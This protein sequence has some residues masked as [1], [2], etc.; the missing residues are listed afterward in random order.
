MRVP[1]TR[2]R[3]KAAG[4]AKPRRK[5]RSLLI[6]CL[7]A[8]FV[9][10]PVGIASADPPIN[11]NPNDACSPAD[12]P[13]PEEYGSGIDGMVRPPDYPSQQLQKSPPERLTYYDRYGT[14]GQ[15]WHPVDMGC[16]DA[17]AMVGNSVSNVVFT[18]AKAFDRTTITIYEAAAS[19]SLLGWL[20]KTVDGVIKGM[21]NTFGAKYWSWVVILGA[22]W[23]AW[24]GLIRRRASR[25][26]EGTIW[27]VMAMVALVWL[28]GRP[29]DFTTLGTKVSNGATAAFNA[30]LPQSNADASACVPGGPTAQQAVQND[31]VTRNANGLWTTLVCKPWLMGEFG[32][33]DAKS[34]I[35]QDNAARLL[36][37]QAVDVTEVYSGKKPDVDQKADDYKA[38]TKNIKD[39][40]PGVYPLFQGKNWTS[41]LAVSFGALLAA[42]VA[43][44][45]VLIIAVMLMVLKI[46]FLLLLVAGPIFL[47]IGIHPGIGRVI[48][49]RWFELLLST[50]LKQAALIG[51]LALLLWCYGLVMAESLPWG[52]QILLIS[53]VTLAAFIYRKPFQH[54]FAAV[55]YSAVGSRKSE[56]HLEQA[57][58]ETRKRTTAV[59]TAAVPGTAG[60]RFGRWAAKRETGATTTAPSLVMIDDA[61]DGDREQAGGGAPAGSERR[62][63]ASQLAAKAAGA[64][65]GSAPPLNLSPRAQPSGGRANGGAVRAPRSGASGGSTRPPAA[66][67]PPREDRPSAPSGG[68]SRPPASAIGPS[69]GA[70]GRGAGGGQG[71]GGAS[72]RR[73][74]GG[75]GGRGWFGGGSEKEG[76][77]AGSGGGR[78]WFGGSGG[79]NAARPGS[80]R[81][82]GPAKGGSDGKREP[83]SGAGRRDTDGAEGGARQA[84]P[85]WSG[86]SREEAPAM[87]FWLRPVKRDDGEE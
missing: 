27:M 39:N 1:P 68:G 19:E 52:L 10:S 74:D 83:A 64:P 44:L 38:V 79:R 9:L 7:M 75:N 54:L 56:E 43:G 14:Q 29:S 51:V 3:R 37:A 50:L 26:A 84:P 73:Q 15:F 77:G 6:L 25:V 63:R 28:I 48:A 11:T 31:A 22:L 42:L 13:S 30:A 21:G 49:T 65:R 20:K 12:H 66:G 58:R 60:Y 61:R 81:P 4:P 5:R 36:S 55:G 23:L 53:L 82:S 59:A 70:S 67:S 57:V 45:L 85:L 87:P 17:M 46:S 35:V 33:D 80:D 72:P 41:R 78:G 76:A 18:L 69:W 8:V 2:R 71:S 62:G 24:W 32:T 47:G 34:K 86:K 16:S 40:Y